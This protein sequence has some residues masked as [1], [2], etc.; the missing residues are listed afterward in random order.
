MGPGAGSRSWVAP[1]RKYFH[2]VRDLRRAGLGI[3]A[4]SRL[5]NIDTISTLSFISSS[6]P[7]PPTAT[8][9]EKRALQVLT[10]SPYHSWPHSFLISL[11]FFG[12]PLEFTSLT[13]L[14]LAS[15]MRCSIR[16][17]TTLSTA[18]ATLNSLWMHD[19]AILDPARRAWIQSWIASSITNHLMLAVSQVSNFINIPNEI[20]M[21]RPA[22]TQRKVFKLLRDA[23]STENFVNLLA[24]RLRRFLHDQA[25]H[26]QAVSSIFSRDAIAL[27]RSLL[28]SLR[29]GV[30]LDLLA[31]W[32]NAWCVASRFGA[33]HSC[34]YC[35]ECGPDSIDSLWR[36]LAL[37]TTIFPML[38]LPV[39][40]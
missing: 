21:D 4:T 12:F 7:L 1:L 32:L 16:S 36:C 19:D 39:P 14:A 6:C 18:A 26:V 13:D 27:L 5:Y 9:T 22:S 15:S 29:P 37:R 38:N 35:G 10:A 3:L 28:R 23:R 33:E 20:L 25:P 40:E 8:T 11:K 17:T 24:R 30:V 2:R 34:R 31:S